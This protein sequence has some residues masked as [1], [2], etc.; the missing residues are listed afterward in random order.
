[1]I[2]RKNV[3]M[4]CLI[5]IVGHHDEKGNKSGKAEKWQGRKIKY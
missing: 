3:A 1:M 2:N 5:L 4:R